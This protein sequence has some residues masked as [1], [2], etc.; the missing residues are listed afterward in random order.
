M[1]GVVNHDNA[2][3]H[4]GDFKLVPGLNQMRED[5]ASEMADHRYFKQLLEEGRVEIM[6]TKGMIRSAK[7]WEEGDQRNFDLEKL[8]NLAVEHR[9]RA[10]SQ[11]GDQLAAH[12]SMLIRN[13]MGSMEACQELANYY[14]LDFEDV[15]TRLHG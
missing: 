8:G 13:G 9:R 15:R 14:G 2:V 5:H 7:P 6:R 11:Q 12:H 10:I 3:F 1:I 4:I